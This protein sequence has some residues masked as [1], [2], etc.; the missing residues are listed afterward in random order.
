M[1]HTMDFF[2][3]LSCNWSSNKKVQQIEGEI[4]YLE[5]SANFHTTVYPFQPSFDQQA[6]SEVNANLLKV[7][8]P[9]SF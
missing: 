3:G 2:D 7:A 4:V 6:V 8:K 1:S 9:E 5:N